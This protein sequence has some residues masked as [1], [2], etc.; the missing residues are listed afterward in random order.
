M[1]PPDHR[2]IEAAH[3]YAVNEAL[4]DRRFI[5]SVIRCTTLGTGGAIFDEDLEQEAL[6]RICQAILKTRHVQYPKAFVAKIVRDTLSDHWRRYRIFED[7]DSLP[8]H[9]LSEEP[10]LDERVDDRRR[11]RSV[12]DALTHLSRRKREIIESFYILE[13]SVTRIAQRFS[14]SPSAVKMTLLRGRRELL[15]MVGGR[16][17]P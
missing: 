14:C 11:L 3:L 7:L 12:S 4:L 8:A 13:H 9:F 17:P 10:R 16:P 6:L 1:S 5:R 15:E 2:A